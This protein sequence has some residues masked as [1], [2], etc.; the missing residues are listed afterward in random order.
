[1]SE[2]QQVATEPERQ[3]SSNNKKPSLTS[4]T[5]AEQIA[6]E[7]IKDGKSST[8]KQFYINLMSQLEIEGFSKTQIST[9]GKQIVIEKKAQK[10]KDVPKEEITIGSWWYDTAREQGYIDPHYSHPKN[11]TEEKP[12]TKYELE[13]E[14]TLSVIDEMMEYLKSEK[15]FLKHNP[16]D[17]KI[18]SKI[19]HENIFIMKNAISHA[20][21]RFNNKLK[22]SP[23]HYSILFRQFLESMSSHLSVPYYLHVRKKETFTAKQA[24]KIIRANVKDLPLRYEPK[25]EDES[26][27]CGFSGEQC[28]NCKF[29]RT[30]VTMRIENYET[31]EKGEKITKSRGIRQIHCFKED[32]N[33]DAPKIILPGNE[34][35]EANW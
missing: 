5:L 25:D 32:A 30:E 33:F 10:L 34:I 11:P 20:N 17:S 2:Q 35:S 16:H 28:P 29:F 8:L 22:I 27:A 19:L 23:S 21:D 12:K 18:D 24:G 1:M 14:Q 3:N 15:Q 26:E 31:E 9:I 6:D 7:E 4:Y 13:N